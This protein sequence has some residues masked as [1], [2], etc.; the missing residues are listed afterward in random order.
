[1]KTIAKTKPSLISDSVEANSMRAFLR[2]WQLL[3]AV[4]LLLLASA[5]RLSA[6]TNVSFWGSAQIGKG[7]LK[8]TLNGSTAQAGPGTCT[9]TDCY[10]PFVLMTTPT[11]SVDLAPFQA[12]TISMSGPDCGI[13]AG[14]YF[15]LNWPCGTISNIDMGS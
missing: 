13:G 1:M 14:Y 9:N 12:Y 15:T 2:H 7:T 5:A 4:S 10:C 6:S 3:C 11:N 8:V